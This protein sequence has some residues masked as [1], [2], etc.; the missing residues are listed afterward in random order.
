MVSRL[1]YPLSVVFFRVNCSLKLLFLEFGER[2]PS[3]LFDPRS[4]VSSVFER[5]L[6]VPFLNRDPTQLFYLM[7]MPFSSP[8]FF[9]FK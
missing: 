2:P 1:S 5:K 9:H 4:S 8:Q 6:D 3:F 7:E